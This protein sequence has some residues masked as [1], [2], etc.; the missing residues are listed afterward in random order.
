MVRSALNPDKPKKTG[1]NKAAIRPRNC[2]SMW[3]VRIGDLPTSTPATKAPS[4]VC[5]PMV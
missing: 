5:T 4:T 2:W 1:M 3:R